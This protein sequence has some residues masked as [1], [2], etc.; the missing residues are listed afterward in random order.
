MT[1]PRYFYNIEEEDST[2]ILDSEDDKFD[3]IV[4]TQHSAIVL[5]ALNNQQETKE[6]RVLS[7]VNIVFDGPPSNKS[8]RFV[9]VENDEGKSITIG[10]WTERGNDWL[11][12]IK[13]NEN[14]HEEK[15]IAVLKSVEW[16]AGD[17]ILFCPS[18][19]KVH[20]HG[21]SIDC[22]LIQKIREYESR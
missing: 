8:G 17:G 22:K 5:H 15:L 6:E 4:N 19:R 20:R 11:L 1:K 18:C 13:L 12:R 16:I 3:C 2:Q 7:A 14:L 21:H 10:E 9:E